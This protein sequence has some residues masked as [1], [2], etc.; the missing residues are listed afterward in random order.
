[1][2]RCDNKRTAFAICEGQ[3]VRSVLRGRRPVRPRKLRHV[4]ALQ[5][6]R[7]FGFDTVEEAQR[8]LQAAKVE[9]LLSTKRNWVLAF[10]RFNTVLICTLALHLLSVVFGSLTIMKRYPRVTCR[11]L[12]RSGT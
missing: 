11:P 8:V 2:T 9:A 1:M 6:D 10:T 3:A 12:C 4:R 7:C 5:V